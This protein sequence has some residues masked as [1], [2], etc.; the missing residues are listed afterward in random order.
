[1]RYNLGL[2][3]HYVTEASSD[4]KTAYVEFSAPN[5]RAMQ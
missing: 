3:Y 5:A 2:I 1:M 4:K